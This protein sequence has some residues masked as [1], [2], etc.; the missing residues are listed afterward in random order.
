MAPIP[1]MLAS[2]NPRL[3]AKD[4]WAPVSCF[5]FEF[6]MATILAV[7]AVAGALKECERISAPAWSDLG[8]PTTR[9]PA[10]KAWVRAGNALRSCTDDILIE[11]SDPPPNSDTVFHP[12]HASAARFLPGFQIVRE[13]YA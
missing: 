3:R 4:T 8:L 7:L 1:I 11:M 13:R 12:P 5:E 6:G 2:N 9:S 10:R